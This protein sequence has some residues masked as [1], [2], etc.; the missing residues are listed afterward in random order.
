MEGNRNR[1]NMNPRPRPAGVPRPASAA[2]KKEPAESN[3][4]DK[5]KKSSGAGIVLMVVAIITL[6]CV[7]GF[8][9][10]R[11]QEKSK[12]IMASQEKIE[13]LN[14]QVEQQIADLEAKKQEL[15]AMQEVAASLKI[16]ADSLPI[17]IQQIEQLQADLKKANGRAWFF[18]KKYKESLSNVDIYKAKMDSLITVNEAAL[19]A[20]D[21]LSKTTGLMGDTIT[22]IK[23]EKE[24]LAEKVAIASIMKGEELSVAG[25]NSKGKQYEGPEFKSK[26]LAKLKFTF[27]L[28]ENKV[29][30]QNEKHIVMRL[31]EPDGTVLFSGTDGGSFDTEDGDEKMFSMSQN[32]NFSGS[33]QKVSFVYQKGNEF[34]SGKHTIEVYADGHKI[35]ETN[36][37]VK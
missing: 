18:N 7:V 8:L 27:Y 32:V 20:V 5:E 33:K 22:S 37:K 1:G 24:V 26:Q 17:L 13:K 29:A 16:K 21:S 19:F 25:Y 12:V 31:I 35:G 10:F 30:P 34:K 2:P 3:P 4:N 28:A 23:Q 6:C 9:L 36:F 14:V 11:D 15:I